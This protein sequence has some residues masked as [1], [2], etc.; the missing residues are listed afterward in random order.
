MTI[1]TINSDST[2]EEI[3]DFYNLYVESFPKLCIHN[4]KQII[5]LSEYL[6]L[7]SDIS[8]FMGDVEFVIKGM[9][10]VI[11][12]THND[13]VITSISF[14]E[15]DNITHCYAVV[16]F[17]CG[18]I[19]TKDIKINGK[20]QGYIMLD[21]IFQ[22]YR[23]YVILI[24]PATEVLIPY[25]TKYKSPCFPY[26]GNNMKETY[27]FLV[28]GNLSRLNEV[29]FEKIFRSLSIINKLKEKLLFTSL[30][31][32]YERT[33]DLDSFKEKL[34]RKLVFLIR[35]KQLAESNYKEFNNLI[36]TI[37]YY[38][39]DEIIIAASEF[40]HKSSASSLA[41]Y[42]GKTKSSSKSKS[43][44]SKRIK[45]RKSTKNIKNRKNKRRT[46]RK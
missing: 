7:T 23:E 33:S 43:I 29:C 26:R 20:S 6:T 9:G 39:I 42:G 40:E 21:Y 14:I 27:N 11:H 34:H 37:N 46:Y 12:Y 31:D 4:G 44:T 2:H 24:E 16:N 30:D 5:D 36:N 41:K 32:L 38:N 22:T 45:N 17:L 13:D 19:E 8:K 28:Y 25:Y 10:L 35:T 1:Y 18:N 15:T 3:E